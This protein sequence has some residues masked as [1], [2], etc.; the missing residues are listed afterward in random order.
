MSGKSSSNLMYRMLAL[1]REMKKP[2]IKFFRKIRQNLL[3]E[4][5]TAKYLKYAIGEIV[6]VVIGILIA[7]GIN[8]RYNAAKNEEKIRAI[9]TQAQE[10]I[11]VDIKDAK[12]IFNEFIITD[13][14]ARNILT[15][16]VSI[17]TN[18]RDLNF[19]DRYVD[20]NNNK[21]AFQQ[22]VNNLENLPEKY[23]E[24]VPLFT[25]IY[26]VLQSDIDRA[27]ELLVSTAKN[28][29]FDRH[30]TEPKY[31]DYEL[32]K[33]SEAE[34]AS[35]YLNDPF[36]K[37][38]TLQYAKRFAR[39]SRYANIFRIEGTL[40]YNMIDSLL[41]NPKSQYPDLLRLLPPEENMTTY[42]GDYEWIEGAKALEHTDMLV[43]IENDQ[44]VVSHQSGRVAKLYWVK[45]NYFFGARGPEI[46]RFYKNEKGQHFLERSNG[47]MHQIWINKRDID[48]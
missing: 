45:E 41:G 31:A 28:I 9:L 26:V 1:I 38:K 23:T 24:L 20:F 40:L 48:L 44:L 25:D 33:Y 7:V 11:L 18:I 43:K 2:M 13:S 39:V 3:S 35:Y 47:T 32:E 15:D 14:R 36:L 37:N 8:S 27:N 46:N 34:T 4:G 5:K 21:S 6:L 19:H 10:N 42:Q 16:S 22:L 29:N 12:R 30:T 17:K